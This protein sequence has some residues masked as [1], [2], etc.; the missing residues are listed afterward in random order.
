MCSRTQARAA[1]AER[2]ALRL[3]FL[4]ANPA[5]HPEGRIP[6]EA[7][8]SYLKGDRSQWKTALPTYSEVVYKAFWTGIDLVYTGTESRLKYHLSHS[9]RAQDP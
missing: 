5:V 3:D 9:G 6:T 1:I 4:G 8:V 2:H 7:I